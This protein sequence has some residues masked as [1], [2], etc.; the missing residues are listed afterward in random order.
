MAEP[1][2]LVDQASPDQTPV[3]DQASASERVETLV[4]NPATPYADEPGF[5]YSASLA[6]IKAADYALTPGRYVGAAEMEDD[7]EPIQDK[8][9]RLSKELFEQFEESERLARVVREQLGR[10]S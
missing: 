8:I 1:T 4:E 6:E 3:V 5:C 7:D 10:V 2:P 9:E